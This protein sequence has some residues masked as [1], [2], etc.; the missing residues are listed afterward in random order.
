MVEQVAALFV[1]SGGAYSHREGVDP[2]AEERDARGYAGPFPVVAHPPCSRWC[3]LAGLVQARYGHRVGDDGGCF[4]SA[5]ASVRIWGGVLEHP[6][7]SKAWPH[8]GLNRPPPQGGWVEAGDGL[9]WCCH[10][11]Q[12]H[13]GHRA[14]KATWLYVAGISRENLPDLRWGR[15]VGACLVSYCDNRIGATGQRYRLPKKQA[16]AT[17]PEFREVLIG[18]ARIACH[19]STW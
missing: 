10:V 2:W 17:P 19:T 13:Y 4:S 15:V 11:E 9:G 12:G 16:A 3:Q 8:F 5:L 14:R 1:Q 7:Y 6:A 18:L